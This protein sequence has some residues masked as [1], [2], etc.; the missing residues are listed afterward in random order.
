MK[1][2]IPS[3]V[4]LLLIAS[5][6]ATQERLL[7]IGKI[8]PAARETGFVLDEHKLKKTF[9]DG[10]PVSTNS[11]KKIGDEY[12]L[13]RSA[14]NTSAKSCRNDFIPLRLQSNGSVALVVNDNQVMNINTCTGAPCESCELVRDIDVGTPKKGPRHYSCHC[15]DTTGICNHSVSTGSQCDS[16]VC[17]GPN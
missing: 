9:P 3:V 7:P 16:T 11:V 15:I 1:V 6:C 2:F 8:D 14:T 17:G 4:M 13:V 10:T 5:G 12:F